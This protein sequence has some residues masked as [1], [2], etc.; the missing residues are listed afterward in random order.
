[1]GNNTSLSFRAKRLTATGYE[2]DALSIRSSTSEADTDESKLALEV[3][4]PVMTYPNDGQALHDR[5]IKSISV[6]GGYVFL[7]SWDHVASMWEL[8]SGEFVRSFRGHKQDIIGVNATGPW[9]FTCG[10]CVRMWDSHTGTQIAALGSKD[11][12]VTLTY[13][14]CITSAYIPGL[15]AC[16]MSKGPIHVYNFEQQAQAYHS[17][18]HSHKVKVGVKPVA[19]LDGHASGV[20]ALDVGHVNGEVVLV[21]GSIDKTARLW[22]LRRGDKRR[23]F[24]GHAAALRDVKLHGNH[25]YTASLDKTARQWDVHTG[26]CTRLFQGHSSAVRS[27]CVVGSL[28]IT[29]EAPAPA[30]ESGYGALREFDVHTGEQMAC[31]RNAHD[32]GIFH[33][34][35]TRDSRGQVTIFSGSADCFARRWRLVPRDKLRRNGSADRTQIAKQLREDSTPDVAD[36]ETTSMP[37]DDGAPITAHQPAREPKQTAASLSAALRGDLPPSDASMVVEMARA[38]LEEFEEAS[39]CCVCLERPKNAAY[40]PCGHQ[41]CRRCAEHFRNKACPMCRKPVTNILALYG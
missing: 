2:V 38:K 28:L 23:I 39:R 30:D 9:L 16:A 27:V 13:Y 4:Q 6:C 35:K 29:A 12:D 21:S 15:V 37:S 32:G 11:L 40:V 5:T 18:P 24:V 19:V 8:E 10:D 36:D 17:K 20:M 7:G 31:H 34:H 33:L 41:S 25:L 1:M 26:A 14:T 22:C 3:S